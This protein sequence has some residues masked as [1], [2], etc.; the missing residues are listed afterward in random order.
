MKYT[1]NTAQPTGIER[2]LRQTLTQSIFSLC[3]RGKGAES[4]LNKRRKKTEEPSDRQT[5]RLT[6]RQAETDT[7]RQTGRDRYYQTDRQAETHTNRH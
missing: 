5:D 2:E 3:F 7:T 6:D 4:P 1:F